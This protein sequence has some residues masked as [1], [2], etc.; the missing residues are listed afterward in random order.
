L[1]KE[2]QKQKK[3]ARARDAVL[4]HREDEAQGSA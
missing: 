3:R 2:K 1:K 4:P